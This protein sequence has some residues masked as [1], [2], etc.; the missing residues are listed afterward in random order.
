MYGLLLQSIVEL[1]KKKY[2]NDTW[3]KVKK[4]ARLDTA[5]FSTHQQYG[6][7]IVQKIVKYLAEETGYSSHIIKVNLIN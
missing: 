4:K 5:T 2:G 7:T 1:I 6:E 3:E